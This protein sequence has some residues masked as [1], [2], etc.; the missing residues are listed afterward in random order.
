[1]HA[2]A[3][4]YG[5]EYY[6]NTRISRSYYNLRL[7]LQDKRYVILHVFLMIQ[8]NGQIGTKYL[9]R[10]LANSLLIFRPNS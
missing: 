5:K 8:I 6:L 4:K 10:S 3:L 9:V 2:N 7:Q 1:M